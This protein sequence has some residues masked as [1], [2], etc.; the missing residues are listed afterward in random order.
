MIMINRCDR[1]FGRRGNASPPSAADDHVA[2]INNGAAS[3]DPNVRAGYPLAFL[4]SA[5]TSL[6][7]RGERRQY[8]NG[9]ER[10]M[11]RR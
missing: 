3:I 1:P 11:G 6:A 10:R 2:A 8:D 5:L 4:S 9:D 7:Q